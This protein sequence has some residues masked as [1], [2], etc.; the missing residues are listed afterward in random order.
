MGK[1]LKYK[2]PEDMKEAIDGYLKNCPDMRVRYFK[3]KD[4]VIEKEV[5]CPTITGLALHL[6]FESRQSF[7]DYEKRPSYS[8]IIKRARTFIEKEYEMMLQQGN[9]VGAIFALKNMGW[10]DKTETEITGKGIQIA[11]LNYMPNQGEIEQDT[12]TD[13]ELPAP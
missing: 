9:T 6:G 10:T 12:D 7:Y 5:P 8:Y 2:T 11:V 1:P 13:K 4:D 3:C